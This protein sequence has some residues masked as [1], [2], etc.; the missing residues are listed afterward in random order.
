MDIT[1][2]G[3]ARRRRYPPCEFSAP[4][5]FRRASAPIKPDWRAPCFPRGCAPRRL[6]CARVTARHALRYCQRGV[7]ETLRNTENA[8]PI[9][10]SRYAM[11]TKH[12]LACWRRRATPLPLVCDD[13]LQSS[14]ICGLRFVALFTSHVVACHSSKLS[15]LQLTSATPY[16]PAPRSSGS[17]FA[18][19]PAAIYILPLAFRDHH[20]AH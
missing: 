13:C 19:A 17:G 7:A 10:P 6:A 14:C 2:A 4:L 1:R 3:V 5:F 20:R 8:I 18:A 15:A 12:Q 16:N 11:R 9:T